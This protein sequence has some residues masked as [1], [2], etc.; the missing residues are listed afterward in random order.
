M[1]KTL[2][3][4]GFAEAHEPKVLQPVPYFPGGCDNLVEL[5]VR[6]RIEV[7]DEPARLLGLEGLRCSKGA[8][9]RQPPEPPQLALRRDRTGGRVFASPQTVTSSMRLDCPFAV[10]RWKN[11]SLP[12]MPSGNRIIEQGR[13]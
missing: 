6:R 12:V 4:R 13:P 2:A 11:C 3:A 10:C 9:P 8:A 5:N 7:K 1:C